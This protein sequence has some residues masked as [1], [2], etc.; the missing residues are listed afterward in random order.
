M[1][2]EE[3]KRNFNATSDKDFGN[4]VEIYY[5][6]LDKDKPNKLQYNENE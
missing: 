6:R 4:T 1:F 5:N 3:R 2:L